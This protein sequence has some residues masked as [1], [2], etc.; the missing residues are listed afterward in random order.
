MHVYHCCQYRVLLERL[1]ITAVVSV[2]AKVD[3]RT[4]ALLMADAQTGYVATAGLNLHTV[5]L[6][7]ANS[8]L[9]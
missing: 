3:Q 7:C 5:R 1:V 2:T 9:V 6:V 4:A 8:G